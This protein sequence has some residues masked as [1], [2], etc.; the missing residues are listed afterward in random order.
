LVKETESAV[1]QIEGLFEFAR[2]YEK[3]GTEE[4]AYVDAEKAF[5]EAARLFPS[6]KDIRIVNDC[7]GLTV[8]ADSL[9]RQLFYNLIDNS[10]KHGEK[11]SQV[12]VHYETSEDRLKLIYEDDGIGV[13]KAEKDKIFTEGYGK[14]SGHGLCLIKK[15]CE[16]YG[17]TI[18]ETGRQGTGAQF[19][20][21]IR[22]A[23]P[24]GRPNYK[25]G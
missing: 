13:P 11:V 23:K 18:Q 14:G 19:T 24:N 25:L 1:H 4:L 9:L 2:I 17:W 8:F 3:L 10:L 6:L 21:N 20:I 22:K 16:V 12:R 5:N 15:M 7:H